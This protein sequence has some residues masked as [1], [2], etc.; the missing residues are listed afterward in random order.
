MRNERIVN[1]RVNRLWE[2]RID[3]QD[4]ANIRRLAAYQYRLRS[5][6]DAH[7][8][9]DA[10]ECRQVLGRAVKSRMLRQRLASR[11]KCNLNQE[12]DINVI[13]IRRVT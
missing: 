8:Q 11:K 3:A 13:P 10:L 5:S 2:M 1:V 7:A 12:G 4:A 9:S 6:T